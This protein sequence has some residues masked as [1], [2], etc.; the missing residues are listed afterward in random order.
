[1]NA[2]AGSPLDPPE[3]LPLDPTTPL[4]VDARTLN[5]ATLLVFGG[6]FDPVHQAHIALSGQVRRQLEALDGRPTWLVLTP[7]GRSPHKSAGPVA[8]DDDRLAMLRLAAQ[9]E[10]RTMVW[11]DEIDRAVRVPRP[12]YTVESLRRLRAWLDQHGAADAR[13]RLLIGADQALAFHRWVEPRAVLALAPPAVMLRPHPPHPRHPP[14]PTSGNG[15]GDAAGFLAALR[16]GGGWSD[17][18]M[19]VWA[20]GVIPVLVQDTS[21]TAIRAAIG[22]GDWAFAQARLAAPVADHIR[23]RGLYSGS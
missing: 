4:P 14:H 10:P 8:S 20:Q 3:P 16:A 21:A 6:S 13:L 12:S 5:R 9:A 2:P 11:S 19:A 1:M 18:D 15:A 7:A 17:A 23:A 22:R